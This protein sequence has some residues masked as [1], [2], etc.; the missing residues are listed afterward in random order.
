MDTE[1]EEKAKAE[2]WVSKHMSR[3]PNARLVPPFGIRMSR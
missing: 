1:K 2:R 3:A